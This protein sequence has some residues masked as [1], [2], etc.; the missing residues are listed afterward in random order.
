MRDKRPAGFP[1]RLKEA[2]HSLNVELFTL[3]DHFSI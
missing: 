3:G 1:G 2:E